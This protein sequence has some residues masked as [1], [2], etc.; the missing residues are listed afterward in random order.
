M[1]ESSKLYRAML[2]AVMNAKS[3]GEAASIAAEIATQFAREAYY[4]S[5]FLGFD[6]WVKTLQDTNDSK[7][8]LE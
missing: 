6:E 2:E 4:S 8:S 3:D 5:P 1:S 7:Q